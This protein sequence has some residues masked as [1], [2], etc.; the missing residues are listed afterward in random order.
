MRIMPW[1][2][3]LGGLWALISSWVLPLHG[4][5]M[6]SAV[7]TGIVVTIGAGYSTGR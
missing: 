1:L 5:A 3:T 6:T 7:I 4:V 2:A